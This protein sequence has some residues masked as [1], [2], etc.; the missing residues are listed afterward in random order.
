MNADH[1]DAVELYATKLMGA[2][3]GKWR[4]TDIDPD[5]ALL[6]LEGTVLRLVFERPVEEPGQLRQTFVALAQKARSK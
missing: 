6:A 5:G 2:G 1:L 4:I 3:G